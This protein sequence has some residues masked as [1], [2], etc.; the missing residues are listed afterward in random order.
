MALLLPFNGT[1]WRALTEPP[2]AGSTHRWLAAAAYR[3][4]RLMSPAGVHEYLRHLCDT[5]VRHRAV[6]DNE[7]YEAI[8]FA[9]DLAH[10][11]RKSAAGLRWPAPSA[12]AIAASMATPPLFGLTG[13]GLSAGQV[14]PWLFAETDLVCW[15]P[16][17]FV[18]HI[19]P[20]EDALGWA[21]TMQYVVPN[22]MRTTQSENKKGDPA[23]RCQANVRAI[24]HLVVEFDREPDRCRQ[25]ALISTLA[26]LGRLVLV[27]S[28]GGKS[29]H[30]WF[31][32]SGLAIADRAKFFAA[33]CLLG[34]DPSLWNHCA[35]V[36]MPGGMRPRDTG[37]VRQEILFWKGRQ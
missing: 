36:R 4:G 35:W 24:R 11:G 26:Q 1:E 30:G 32:V 27:V 29:L 15:G 3:L 13:I 5:Q 18:A 33:A 9:L 19:G 31:D 37:A 25:V 22:P 16:D 12:E 8:D 21:H 14:L 17:K 2:G 10:Q 6:S 34:A 23:I 7:I 28:S 20:I